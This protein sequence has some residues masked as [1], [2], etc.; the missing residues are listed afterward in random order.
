MTPIL[1]EFAKLPLRGY[2]QSFEFIQKHRDV[3]VPGASDALFVA[4]FRAQRA[5]D[6]AR[7][8]RCIHQSMLL[9]YCEKLGKDGVGLFFQRMLSGDPRAEKVFRDDFESTYAKMVERVAVMNA[10]EAEAGDKGEE[11]IQ[12][13]AQGEGTEIRFNV[14]DGPPPEEL[15]LEGPELENV[16]VEEVRHFLTTQWEIFEGFSDE[17]KAALKSGKLDDVNKV[18]EKMDVGEA[19]NVVGLLDSSGILNV[20][21]GV[22]DATG[23]DEALKVEAD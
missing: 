19:E 3:Y 11:K 18:L 20:S 22:V 4:G 21:G 17:M 12:L 6:A 1:D 7:A 5:G 23:K 10:E 14:P 9:Q 8:K 13:V 15:R 16:D 2:S